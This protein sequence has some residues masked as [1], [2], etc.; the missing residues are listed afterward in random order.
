MN[1][2]KQQWFKDAKFGLFI[3]FGLYSQLAGEYKGQVTPFIA[4]WIMNS[5][6]IPVEEY[7][8]LAKTFNPVD[9]DADFIA[10]KAESWGMKYVVITSK[11]H[12]GFAMYDSDVSD[13]NS[14]KATPC[15]RDFVAEM[16]EA[17]RKHGLK[18]GIYYSQ[19]QDWDDPDGYMARHDNS[20]KNY[21]RY[22][23][24]KCLP[25][26]KEL[27]EK[28]PDISL[29]W[30]DTPMGT[31]AEES[32]E[33]ITLVKAI[34]PEVIISGRIGNGL[35]E[36]MT[37]GDNFIPA[38]PFVGDWEVPATLNDTWGFK[39]VDTNWKDPKKLLEL[40][41][42]INSR[43]GN[44]LLNIGPDGKGNVPVRSIEILD[45]VGSYV[46]ANEDAIFATKYVE[47]YPYDLDWCIFTRKENKFFIHVTE[48]KP[49]PE[50]INFFATIKKAYVLDSGV[51]VVCNLEKTCEG[52]HCL[53]LFVPEEYQWKSGYCICL[54]IEE[55][56]PIFEEI[57]L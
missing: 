7:R 28:Y 24:G 14:V 34:N 38:E 57:R 36:Y 42:K 22:L 9:F 48:I 20:G 56:Q 44:Y 31:T 46:K 41:L 15:H 18:F 45:S 21:R 33:M 6:D 16:Q 17:C 39:R 25:Q 37:T 50:I 8:Q 52:P 5:M 19:A 35:G 32:T 30:F 26:L 29:I 51:P 40:L 27:M 47:K 49:R 1:D 55:E 11:H 53:E 2:T 43:G 4:E 3:H 10:A 12:E 13:Y 23:D 54:E